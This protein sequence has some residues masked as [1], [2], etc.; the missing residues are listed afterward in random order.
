M[1]KAEH[2][3]LQIEVALNMEEQRRAGTLPLQKQELL[4]IFL[5]EPRTLLEDK[6][7]FVAFCEA[8]IYIQYRTGTGLEGQRPIKFN[9]AQHAILNVY[10]DAKKKGIPVRCI[11]LKGRQMGFSTCVEVLGFM[12]TICKGGQNMLIASEHKEKSGKKYL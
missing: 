7:K 4:D 8:F 11:G 5:T 9:N 12:D 1:D 10:F 3:E 6:K 2:E